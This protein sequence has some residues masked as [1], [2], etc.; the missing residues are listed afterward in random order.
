MSKK[1]KNNNKK[2]TAHLSLV[3]GKSK[4]SVEKQAVE[5]YQSGNV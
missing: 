2:K 1:T 4:R 5:I 3:K